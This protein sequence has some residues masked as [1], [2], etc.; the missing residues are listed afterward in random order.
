ML[1]GLTKLVKMLGGD[2]HGAVEPC[3]RPTV[4]SEMGEHFFVAQRGKE[5]VLI[6]KR[7]AVEDDAAAVVEVQLQQVV[8]HDAGGSDPFQSVA[9]WAMILTLGRTSKLVLLSLNRIICLFHIVSIK[10]VNLSQRLAVLHA[11]PVLHQFVLVQV[12]PVEDEVQ[13]AAWHLSSHLAR[14]N[15][16]GGAVLIVAHVEVRR[17]MVGQI[18]RDDDSVEVANLWHNLSRFVFYV[19]KYTHIFANNQHYSLK[20]DNI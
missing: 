1:R 18:H 6:D 16:D 13:C 9:L 14:L 7:L 19:G 11:R 3:D 20:S 10:W 17:V 2:V 12:E 5:L 8:A 4:E 15:V